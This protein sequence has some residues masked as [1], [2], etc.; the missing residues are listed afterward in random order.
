MTPKKHKYVNV[1][2]RIKDDIDQ[3]KIAGKLPG[4]RMLA[5]EL[6]VSYMTVRKAIME[7]VSEGILVKQGTK[8]TFVSDKKLTGRLTGN[9]GFFLDE[10]I[11]EGISSP[12]YSLVF[13]SLERAVTAN[14]YNLLLFTDF[15]DLNPVKNTRKID[16]AIICCF[17]RIEDDIQAIKKYY[18]IVLLDNFAAD[19]SIPSITLD[20]FNSF[21]ESTAYLISLGHKR[22]GFVSGLLDSDICRNRLQGYKNALKQAGIPIEKNLVFKGDYSYESGEAAG[23]YFANL[24]TPPTAIICANDSMA[25]GTMKVIQEHGF[26]I[27]GDISIIGFDDVLVASKV[28]PALCTSA[29]PINEMATKAVEILLDEIKGNNSDYKHIILEAKLI[30]RASC[31]PPRRS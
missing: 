17:P 6:D 22:I 31:A 2:S 16:G 3:G 26:K 4:E 13:K 7:L 18:P 15:D 20:N 21:S 30:K 27:P 14:G 11:K 5:Q 28:F 29:A 9:I 10:E 23:K 8:G 25:I 24:D 19:K 1:K 12:Y